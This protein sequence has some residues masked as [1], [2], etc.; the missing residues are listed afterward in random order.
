MQWSVRLATRRV[1]NLRRIA[2][3]TQR[4]PG[5][6]KLDINV[7]VV[8]LFSVPA[9]SHLIAVGGKRRRRLNARITF[10]RGSALVTFLT[11]VR[12]IAEPHTESSRTGEDHQTQHL[13]LVSGGEEPPLPPRLDICSR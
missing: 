13:R 10:V 7:S 5:A 8:L 1:G 12:V 2:G 9:E 11:P 3:Q 4:S 6:N